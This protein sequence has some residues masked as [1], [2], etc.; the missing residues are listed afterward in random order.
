MLNF[1]IIKFFKNVAL[2][3]P[4]HKMSINV[5]YVKTFFKDNSKK[6]YYVDIKQK[7]LYLS[8]IIYIV[9]MITIFAVAI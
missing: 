6:V 5:G 9:I 1:K 3:Q 4:Y 8:S 7:N 2:L